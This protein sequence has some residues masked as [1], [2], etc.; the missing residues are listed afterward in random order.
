MSNRLTDYM[1][2]IS[3]LYPLQFGFRTGHSTTDMTLINM[4]ELITEAIDGNR[5]S[6]GIF[7]DLAKAFDTIDHSI[8]IKKIICLWYKRSP[9]AMV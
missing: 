7:L 4:H 3:V 6:V 9:P 1:E 5:Y 2:K 8:L